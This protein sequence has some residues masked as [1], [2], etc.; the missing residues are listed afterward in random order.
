MI[1]LFFL[2]RLE[3]IR[4]C[5][6]YW[7]R[8]IR[9]AK[10]LLM[11]K[12]VCEQE[13]LM[14]LEIRHITLFLRCSG[15]PKERIAYLPKAN[16]WWGPAGESGHCGPDT[17]MFYYTGKKA[18]KKFN[19][20]DSKWVEIWNDVFMQYNKTKDGKYELLKQKNVDTGM[21]VER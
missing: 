5:L 6:F 21:G 17:E 14:R 4:L 7:G 10:E 19:P 15:I 8:S 3:C 9:L 1:R 13:I 11:C 18:P 12:S 16:N 2:R 20:D